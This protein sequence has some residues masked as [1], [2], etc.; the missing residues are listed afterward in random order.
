MFKVLSYDYRHY[1]AGLPDLLLVR[2]LTK[3]VDDTH[4][5]LD[6]SSWVGE[7][8]QGR[9]TNNASILTDR[10]EEFIYGDKIERR[11]LSSISQRQ[12]SEITTNTDYSSKL[13]L[14][15]D[16]KPV[17]IQCLF[18]E[19]KSQN[20]TLDERQEDWI[21]ILDRYGNARLCK[22]KGKSQIK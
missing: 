6:L 2:A 15:D 12:N 3:H 16:G 22:F 11:S 10:D 7:I 1:G 19:V 17:Q 9:A 14:E 20:D 8:F 18:V 21:N 5:L 13:S 4:Q